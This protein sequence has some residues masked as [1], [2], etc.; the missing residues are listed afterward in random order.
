ML[1]KN[2][3]W[4]RKVQQ[5]ARPHAQKQETRLEA[6]EVEDKKK[7]ENCLLLHPK[8]GLILL[9]LMILHNLTQVS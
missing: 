8:P 5:L 7:L 2:L 3:S 1:D 9:Q 4:T 6:K